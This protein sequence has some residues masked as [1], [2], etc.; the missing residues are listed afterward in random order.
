LD[1]ICATPAAVNANPAIRQTQKYD[2]GV[3][4][5]RM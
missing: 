3:W 5:S 1:T 2:L 4:G